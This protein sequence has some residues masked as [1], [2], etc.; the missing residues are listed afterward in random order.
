MLLAFLLAVPTMALAG[1]P[2]VSAAELTG[3][4]SW[5]GVR[6]IRLSRDA[7]IAPAA[8]MR[9]ELSSKGHVTAKIAGDPEGDISLQQY[10][11]H[12]RGVVRSKKHGT[13]LI[14]QAPGG[15]PVVTALDPATLVGCETAS[16]PV[17][18]V[19]GDGG[20]SGSPPPPPLAGDGPEGDA[21]GGVDVFVAYTSLARVN[22]GSV[23]AMNTA[24]R[25]W[26]NQTNDV[27]RDSDTAVRIRLVGTDEVDY[28]ESGSYSNHISRL[29]S[30][31]DGIMDDV[32]TW[33]ADTGADIVVLMVTDASSCGIGYLIKDDA[34]GYPQYAFAVVRDYCADVQYSF[35]HELGHVMGCCHD[36][37]HA[38]S[39]AGGDSLYPY[40]F[41][42]RFTGDS[43]DWRTVMAYSDGSG[44]P[45]PWTY[46]TRIGRFSNPD[47]EYDG[48]STG[49]VTCDNAATHDTMRTVTAAYVASQSP[50]TCPGDL[51]SD[52]VVGVDDLLGLLQRWGPVNGADDASLA[53]DLNGDAEV[54]TSD[55]LVQLSEFG[56][57]PG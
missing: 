23:D 4:G 44:D 3:L 12:V 10:K 41:G 40:A 15:T 29:A 57:C 5:Q 32:H 33:R 42:K 30:T 51:G 8:P 52:A 13:W 48:E 1:K 18:G 2:T 9:L 26:V 17:V 53:A 45:L 21:G 34:T 19:D 46:Y 6:S 37:D 54:D 7:S 39:C 11:G 14:R 20:G 22:A 49:S 27:Y 36:E 31:N 47:L 55:L 24:V 28:D 35:A 43:G 16:L 50:I 38:G 25:G 56:P